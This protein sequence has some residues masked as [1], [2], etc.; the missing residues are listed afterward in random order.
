MTKISRKALLD[1]LGTNNKSL[2]ENLIEVLLEVV[3]GDYD[4]ESFRSDIQL[5]SEMTELNKGIM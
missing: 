2:S 5:Y 4:L 3:N 1:W